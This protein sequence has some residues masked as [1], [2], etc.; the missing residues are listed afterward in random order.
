MIEALNFAPSGFRV[1]YDLFH[2]IFPS[3]LTRQTKPTEPEPSIHVSSLVSTPSIIV[4]LDPAIPNGTLPTQIFHPSPMSFL[5][6]GLYC[7]LYVDP[8][9]R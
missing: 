9:W 7:T 6:T 1:S 2:P 3:T 8:L 4:M 5:V